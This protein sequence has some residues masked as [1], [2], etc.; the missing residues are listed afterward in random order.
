MLS[1]A[2]A[3][4][5][6]GKA[7]TK[8]SLFAK[9]S[10]SKTQDL[11]NSDLFHRSDQTYVASTAHA[12]RKRQEKLARKEKERARPNIDGERA[13]KR[14]RMSE[15]ED[16]EDD[17]D[18]DGNDDESVVEGQVGEK[19]P[20]EEGGVRKSCDSNARSV[21]AS[22]TTNSSATEIISHTKAP[23]SHPKAMPTLVEKYQKKVAE[24]ASPL[25]GSRLKVSSVINIDDDEDSSDAPELSQVN[26]VKSGRIP[27]PE[28][29]EAIA[30]DEEFPEL[31]RKAR[32]RARRKRLEQDMASLTPELPA[33]TLT[34]QLFASP[35][36]T[37]PP[38]PPDPVLQIL[39]TSSIPNTIPLIVSRKLGQRLKEV[40]LAWLSR[41]QLSN[42]EEVFLT[43]RGKRL[44]DVTTCRSLGV[45]VELDGTVMAKGD[46]LGD[47]EGRIHMEAMT[48]EILEARRRAKTE[49]A[50]TAE[51]EE[52]GQETQGPTEGKIENQVRI[53]LKARG[54]D[55]FKLRVKPVSTHCFWVSY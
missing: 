55:D 24:H 10:W 7:P 44:F 28:V 16:D 4:G 29:E 21:P 14:Q 35:S 39:I 53:I 8:R 38:Q 52:A 19:K 12:E 42:Q 51:N 15:D 37:L 13:S 2:S 48:L 5:N 26:V 3:S 31:V 43:W 17:E 1:T 49:A 22:S 34:N 9:P 23:S 36:G 46:V 32:E 47:E 6:S 18:M 30:S 20:E 41:Q 33:A 40:K 54:F 11:S 27:R 50:T 25:E 45:T